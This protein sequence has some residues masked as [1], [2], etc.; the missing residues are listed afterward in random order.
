MNIIVTRENGVATVTLNRPDKL[1]ALS[2]EMYHELAD[3]FTALGSDDAARCVIVTG[4]GR[5]SPTITRKGS[6]RS[7]RSGSPS[8]KGDSTIQNHRTPEREKP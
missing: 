6:P 2:G 4:A 8:F 5:G 3:T 7:K 1:N